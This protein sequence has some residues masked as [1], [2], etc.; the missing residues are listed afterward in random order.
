MTHISPQVGESDKFL[1]VESGIRNTTQGILNL[2]NDWNPESKFH[3]KDWNP[4][5]GIWNPRR[6]FQNPRPSWIPLYMG[7]HIANVT[8]L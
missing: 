7:R 4:V 1:L 8:L 6:G 3:D 5:P 2:T